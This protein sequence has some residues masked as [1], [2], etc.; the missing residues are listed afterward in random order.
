MSSPIPDFN[1]ITD[2]E[3]EICERLQLKLHSEEN[4]LLVNKHVFT[5][6]TLMRFLRGR[7]GNEER[8]Y[9][10][11][12]KHI[13][14]RYDNNIEHITLQSIENEINANKLIIT[15]PDKHTLR[16]IITILVRKHNSNQ[17]NIDELKSYIIYNFETA[18]KL[19]N[20][21]EEKLIILFDMTEFT[22]N[23]MDYEVLKMII[24]ILEYNY[25]ESLYR[26]YILSSPFLFS[27]CWMVI[28]PWLD[29]VT[30]SKVQ[31]IEKNVLYEYIDKDLVPP[32]VG[33]KEGS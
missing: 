25:P 11:L 4:I 10:A 29:P 28:R 30:A 9:R 21:N 20:P 16:P 3:K 15:G 24:N 23:N 12:H 5:T 32:E 22:Y 18:M 8:T 1:P 7:K 33:Q 19:T 31:F 17:R 6:T 14:W 2:E 26:A 13:Q 27:G